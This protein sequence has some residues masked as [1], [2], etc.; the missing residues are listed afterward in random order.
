MESST[1]L[2][3]DLSP[4]ERT[5]LE[6]AAQVVIE[7]A[8]SSCVPRPKHHRIPFLIA[9]LR[10]RDNSTGI[11]W[12]RLATSTIDENHLTQYPELTNQ[13]IALKET[14]EE[15]EKRVVDGHLDLV[16]IDNGELQG[17]I[18]DVLNDI[19]VISPLFLW[20]SATPARFTYQ[21]VIGFY[22]S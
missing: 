9:V 7:S 18:E 5:R 13:E 17:T 15:V 19:L 16:R 8:Q 14:L 21:I 1:G 2:P 11:N 10:P 6:T 12:R 4:H 3:R 22:G 20:I